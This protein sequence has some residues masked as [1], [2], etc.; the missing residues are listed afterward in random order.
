MGI[1][2][3][4]IE[5]DKSLLLY[6]NSLH[7]PFWDTTMKIISGKFTWLPLYAMIIGFLIYEK[8]KAS[9]IIILSI[10]VM[11]GLTEHITSQICKP[12]FA[13]FRPT[14]DPSIAHLV[15]IVDGYKGGKYGFFSAHSSNTFALASFLFFSFRRKYSWIGLFFVWSGVVA[16]SRVYLGVHY[17]G[18]IITGMLFGILMGKLTSILYEKIEN[19]WF[20]QLKT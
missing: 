13:R 17:P 15:H 5:L 2:D 19:K 1:I 11:F 10:L 20:P 3:Y 14:H 12:L 18:D 6:L 4:I 16:Y 8:K 7:S 9:W